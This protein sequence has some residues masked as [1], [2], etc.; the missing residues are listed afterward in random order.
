MGTDLGTQIFKGTALIFTAMILVA[1]MIVGL[2]M[3][4]DR[5][6]DYIK[7]NLVPVTDT[8]AYTAAPDEPSPR[9]S[10]KHYPDGGRVVVEQ[11]VVGKNITMTRSFSVG[12]GRLIIEIE[13]QETIHLSYQDAA[14]M[15]IWSGEHWLHR[16]SNAK[17]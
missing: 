6:D 14:V 13:S 7:A 17:L 10:H 3:R 5:L 4:V 1:V 2:T 16:V 12:D 8:F 11:G 15:L 9:Y